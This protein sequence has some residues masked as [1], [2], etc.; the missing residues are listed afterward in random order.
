MAFRLA[1]IVSGFDIIHATAVLIFSHLWEEASSST[2][3]ESEKGYF[4]LKAW[5]YLSYLKKKIFKKGQ[6]IH[7]DFTAKGNLL[8]N[9]LGSKELIRN[10]CRN[11]RLSHV[12]C[13]RGRS[14][15]QA[16][17]ESS[18]EGKK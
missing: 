7:F 6:S 4:T 12:H 3:T 18:P 1:G 8:P 11:T 5:E 13:S 17:S 10:T 14:Y 9:Y 2:I 15:R 16:P